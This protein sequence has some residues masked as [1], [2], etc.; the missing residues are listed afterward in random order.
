ML[1][2]RIVTAGVGDWV[3]VL[4]FYADYLLWRWRVLLIAAG[5]IAAGREGKGVV[6]G[7]LLLGAVFRDVSL[8]NPSPNI[9]HVCLVVYSHGSRVECP[10]FFTEIRYHIRGQEKPK[11]SLAS[12]EAKNAPN[13]FSSAAEPVR[14]ACKRRSSRPPSQLRRWYLLPIFTHLT[15]VV[16]A[17]LGP[18]SLDS[19]LISGGRSLRPVKNRRGSFVE[20]IDQKFPLFLLDSRHR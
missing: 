19:V 6:E 5:S 1:R 13:L 4:S 10:N 17:R 8:S 12:C 18:Q 15:S 14:W 16:S 9:C 2:S 20:G 11:I 3:A 7:A